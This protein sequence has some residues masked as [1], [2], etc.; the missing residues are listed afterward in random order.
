MAIKLP[1]ST[2]MYHTQ[3]FVSK[4]IDSKSRKSSSSATHHKE[5]LRLAGELYDNLLSCRN[6]TIYPLTAPA[7]QTNV[8]KA[9]KCGLK[10]SRLVHYIID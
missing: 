5:I 3:V 10:S 7:T 6:N 2:Y 4:C 9:I 8:I 1:Y